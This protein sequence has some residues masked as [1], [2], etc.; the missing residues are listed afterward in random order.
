M[1]EN[2]IKVFNNFV[3][4]T[5]LFPFSII[6]EYL[7]EDKDI[8]T[9]ILDIWS[10]D[11]VKEAIYIAS[12]DLFYNIE[13]YRKN[14]E[15]STKSANKLYLSIIKYFVRMAS[16]STPFGMF[17]GV[18]LGRF[19]DKTKMIFDSNKNNTRHTRLDMNY[20]CALSKN[21]ARLGILKNQIKYFSNSSLY[22]SSGFARFIE[23]R[24]SGGKRS[25]HIISV[26]LNP[27]LESI[28]KES[29]NGITRPEVINKLK[30]EGFENSES[31]IYTDELINSQ[32]L[33]SELEPSVTRLEFFDQILNIVNN[34]S[35]TEKLYSELKDITRKI[36]IIDKSPFSEKRYSEVYEKLK[37]IGTEFNPK[38]LFQTDLVKKTFCCELNKKIIQD[39]IKAIR[40]LE[41]FGSSSR[42]FELN[43]FSEKYTRRYNEEELP[44]LDVLDIES[45]IGYPVNSDITNTD[46]SAL[47]ENIQLFSNDEDNFI[48]INNYTRLLLNKYNSCIRENKQFIEIT[49]A[50]IKSIDNEENKLTDTFSVL[51]YVFYDKIQKSDMVLIESAGGSSAANLNARFCFADP[52]IDNFVNILVEKEKELLPD[53]ILAEIAHLPEARTGN[54]LLRPSFRDYEIP[55]MASPG[56]KSEFRIKPADLRISV[57][58]GRIILKSEKLGKEILPRL[59][60]AHNYSR[61]SLP[62]YRFLCD[63]QFQDKPASLMFNKGN[64]EEDY[65]FFP[66]IIYKNIILSRAVWNIDFKM[67]KHLDNIRDAKKMKEEFTKWRKINNIPSKTMMSEGDNELFLNFD[68]IHFCR[69]FWDQLRRRKR[70][71]LKEFLFELEAGG[72]KTDQLQYICQYIFSF[73]R[74]NTQ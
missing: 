9:I 60:T 18:S 42:K 17:A 22:K 27:Y 58:D 45:G 37:K 6:E 74:N 55:Y 4:R 10:M 34:Y 29:E 20:I 3:V 49:E 54:I 30:M 51:A 13:K 11:S 47:I 67:I 73:Y 38:Y 14:P 8:N 71:K 35:G 52:E 62:V 32:L 1:K 7:L 12:P 53:K 50:D 66:R 16:R 70:I 59:T 61:S 64:F 21:L 72:D 24:Y 65:F 69:L 26:E 68:N 5:P 2:Q 48:S 36:K 19:G 28:I 39:I 43:E 57:K 40:F 56:V 31:E 33:V 41:K 63:M 46:V 25:H 15:S 44:L 23:Y